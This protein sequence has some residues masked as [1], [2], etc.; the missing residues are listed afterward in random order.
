MPLINGPWWKFSY[1]FLPSTR[2]ILKR[3]EKRA[4]QIKQTAVRYRGKVVKETRFCLTLPA[5]L[6]YGA[7]ID[8]ILVCLRDPIQV[9]RSI[10]RRNF[11][12]IGHALDLWYIHNSRILENS[13]GIPLAFVYYED[14]LN[15]N[16]FLREMK[17][18]YHFFGY[19]FTDDELEALQ[20][21]CVKPHMNHNPERIA[22]YPRKIEVLWQELLQRHK[23][24][25]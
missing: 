4:D 25:F 6:K 3:A 23:D 15:K 18:A 8:K 22:S 7:Q 14:A 20:K 24:Q 10:Q 17:F 13:K 1:F 12:T 16:S 5:W 9:A 21:K 19:D 2:T 11:T